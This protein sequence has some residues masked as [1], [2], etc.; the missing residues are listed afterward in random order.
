MGAL[1]SLSA[2]DALAA[3]LLPHDGGVVAITNLYF[4][5]SG[6]HDGSRVMSVAGYWFERTQSERFS[7][8]WAKDLKRLGLSHAHMTDCAHGHQEYEKLSKPD[9]LKSELLLIEHIKRRS[10][11]GFGVTVRPDR[12]EAVLGG[13]PGAPSCYALCLMICVNKVADYARSQGYDGKLAYFFEAGHKRSS[14]AHKFMEHIPS[15]GLNAMQAQQ[16]SGHA[17]VPK[18]QALPLQAADMFAW[19]LRHH[20]DRNLDGEFPMRKDFVALLRPFDFFVDVTEEH[21]LALRQL[22]IHAGPRYE[23]GEIVEPR[24]ISDTIFAALGLKREDSGR[25]G[26]R[27]AKRALAST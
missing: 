20:L 6:T 19:Q 8:D 24:E 17:F 12:Y 5:E 10:R 13:M 4:D 14:E 27:E 9:R 22:L 2:F 1:A 26:W 11:F 25:W 16:Y 3:V 23:R 15:L 21:L 7:R 18:T